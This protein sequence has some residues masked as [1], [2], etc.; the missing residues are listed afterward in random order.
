MK[1]S[2]YYL[3]LFIFVV[4]TFSC[5]SDY[6]K[7]VNQGLRSGIINDS[8]IFGMKM[9]QTKKD[10]YAICWDL[11]KQ[12]LISE[13]PGNLSARYIEPEDSTKDLTMRKEMLF[14]GIFDDNDTMRGMDMTFNYIAWSP[15]TRK[16]FADSLM[17]DLKQHYITDY[18]GNDFVQ[19]ELDLPKYK[20]FAKVD[21]N[22][23]I[24]MYPKSDREV[25]VKIE[26]LRYK[27]KQ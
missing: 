13:G 17:E 22:R 1:Y 11:N 5:K 20:A 16:F 23:Q 19:I 8:L 3:I 2:L 26:D 25:I 18:P 15:W 10:F 27:L 9:G 4:F 24:L 7:A 14:Y 12:K 6:T 21:G